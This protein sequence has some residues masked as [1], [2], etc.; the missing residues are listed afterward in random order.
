MGEYP[1]K[2]RGF[3]LV[4]AL[5]QLNP[6]PKGKGKEISVDFTA[7]I[8]RHEEENARRAETAKAARE[9]L[10]GKA[11]TVQDNAELW[12]L[13]GLAPMTRVRTSFGDVHAIALR[14]GDKVLLRSGEYKPIQWINRIML[15]DHILSL[16]QDSNPISLSPGSLGPG[17][18]ANEMMVSPRQV[19][20]ADDRTRFDQQREAA[21]LMSR[22]GVRRV[23]ETGLTYTMLHVGETAEIYCEGLFLHF[24]IES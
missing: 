12:P 1:R 2:E 21:T 18:P 20:C 15:D 17:A 9:K 19:I 16:K 5:G 11:A 14:K 4:K 3:G 24:P 22:P 10:E 6:L 7:D 8:E 13:P 23:R